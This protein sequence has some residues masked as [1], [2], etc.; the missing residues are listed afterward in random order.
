CITASA[1]Y[2]NLIGSPTNSRDEAS[3]DDEAR[4]TDVFSRPSSSKYH[5]EYV[6]EFLARE[7]R[8]VIQS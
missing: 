4:A 5:R 7:P 6:R 1:S 3:F 2:P 8:S